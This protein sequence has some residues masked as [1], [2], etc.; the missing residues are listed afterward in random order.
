MHLE[1]NSTTVQTQF[2]IF[3]QY[4]SPF[5]KSTNKEETQFIKKD[6]SQLKSIQAGYTNSKSIII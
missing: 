3:N 2:A 5:E 1:S 4:G 6:K